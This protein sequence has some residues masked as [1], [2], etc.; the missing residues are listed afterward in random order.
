MLHHAP[1]VDDAYHLLRLLL[2][3]CVHHQTVAACRCLPVYAAVVV[4]AH[5]FSY[6]FKLSLVARPADLLDAQFG[7]T[8]AD[9]EEF[10]LPQC[11]IRR[12]DPH[13]G[14]AAA[15]EAS[16]NQS[17]TCGCEHADSAKPVFAA[18]RRSESVFYVLCPALSHAGSEV[19]VA[20]LEDERNLIGHRQSH[21]KG[22]TVFYM[23]ADDVV[24]AI[25]ES[26]GAASFGA[27]PLLVV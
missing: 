5:V 15:R 18:L 22:E 9:G 20:P 8:V 21:G 1:L 19:D 25:R 13:R 17:D 27:D 4:A 24:V 11:E 6:L 16:L 10:K 7:E 2:L 26:V 12:V 14:I 3:V 23:Y